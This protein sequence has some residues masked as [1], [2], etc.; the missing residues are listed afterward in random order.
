MI[1]RIEALRYRSLRYVSQDLRTFQTLVGPNGAGKSNLLDAIEIVR[2][3]LHAGPWKAVM[4]NGSGSSPRAPS[5]KHLCWLRSG[6]GFEIALE[7]VLPEYMQRA[8][9]GSAFEAIRYELGY[10]IDEASNE[11]GLTTENL[12]LLP[13]TGPA[14]RREPPVLFPEARPAP[15]SIVVREKD[16][17]P[18]GWSKVVRKTASSDYFQAEAGNWTTQFRLGSTKSALANLPDDEERF[19]AATW[20]RR[21]L[22]AGIQRLALQSDAMRRPSPVGAG[23]EFRADGS[24]LPWVVHE[25][26]RLQPDRYLRWLE[27][28]RTAIP[29]LEELSPLDR[30]EDN[31]KYLTLRFRNGLAAPSWL[32]SDGT[33]RLLALTLLPYV[34]DPGAVYLV[35]E[36]ENG[37]NPRNIE[38]VLQSLRSVTR[39]Q[40]LCAS[41]SPVLLRLLEPRD[42]LCLAQDAG[43]AT[44]VVSGDQHPRLR[45]WRGGLDLGDVFAAGVLG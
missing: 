39:G 35:E 23:R 21:T 33:L 17:T 15:E 25:L 4:G 44:D 36:P 34:D 32:V 29:D 26:S 10:Q 45:E 31:A 22:L 18:A 7:L 19:P 6:T 20:T 3:T 14:R 1:R 13:A 41:H 38:V 40:V 27:H 9:L 37:L 8:H 43:G 30:P 2:D 12:W 5:A 42:I 24:N 16:R 28:V 11:F